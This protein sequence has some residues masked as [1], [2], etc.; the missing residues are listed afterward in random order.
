MHR[1]FQ[2]GYDLLALWTMPLPPGAAEL[3][4]D[5]AA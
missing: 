3:L 4:I 2:E 5:F 1:Q